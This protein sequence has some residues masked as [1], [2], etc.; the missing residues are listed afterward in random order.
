MFIPINQ[1]ARKKHFTFI[2]TPYMFRIT[3]SGSKKA[4]LWLNTKTLVLISINII[5]VI[6][7]NINIYQQKY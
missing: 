1:A 6:Y 2:R 7:I 4:K 3:E 5:T